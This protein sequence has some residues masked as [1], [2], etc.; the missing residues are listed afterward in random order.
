M[1]SEG[2]TIRIDGGMKRTRLPGLKPGEARS[3]H[4]VSVMDI[5]TASVASNCLW[6][7]TLIVV[8]ARVIDQ[9]TAGI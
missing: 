7:W 2:I 8:R 6:E 3:F 9:H 4:A 1:S 5:D